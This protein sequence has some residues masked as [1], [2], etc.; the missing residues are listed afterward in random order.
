MTLLNTLQWRYATKKFDAGKSLSDDKRDYILEAVR[1]S[2][3]SFGLQPYKILVIENKEI[4]EKMVAHAWNQRQLA[5]ASCLVVF[6][7]WTRIT[8]VEIDAYINDMAQKRGIP[9]EK[10]ADYKG[11]MVG[12]LTSRTPAQL[13]EWAARQCYLALGTLLAAAAEQEV[14]TTPMEGFDPAAFNEILGLGEK[15]LSAVVIAPLGYRASDDT[16]AQLKKV[17]RDKDQLIEFIR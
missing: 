13:Q 6:A 16:Y 3:S 2:A 1:L 10:L 15:N 8:E 7:A 4:R 14:D 17:R 11:M 9:V 5:D 12:S